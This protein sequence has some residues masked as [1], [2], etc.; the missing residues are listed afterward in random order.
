MNDAKRIWPTGTMPTAKLGRAPRKHQPL[1]IATDAP[2]Q[3]KYVAGFRERMD[4]RAKHAAHVLILSLMILLTGCVTLKPSTAI[5]TDAKTLVPNTSDQSATI[6]RALD[7]GERTLI[8]APGYHRLAK[9]ITLPAGTRIVGTNTTIDLATPS[10]W[11][12]YLTGP[13]SFQGVTLVRSVPGGLTLA[14][15]TAAGAS[16]AFDRVDVGVAT[17]IQNIATVGATGS[18]FRQ[19]T[20]WH[21]AIVRDCTFEADTYISGKTQ[22]TDSIMRGRLISGAGTW[23]LRGATVARVR[24]DHLVSRDNTGEC[25]LFETVDV[26]GCVFEDLEFVGCS[27]PT[28]RRTASRTTSS[29]A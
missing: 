29:A 20:Y 8:F 16:I 10:G 24:W 28:P 21:D 2:Q 18:V 27:G 26:E 19:Q 4:Q 14:T 6:Q 11:A 13:V 22:F 12:F 15:G 7:A 3:A 17:S 25:L 5:D 9:T 23:G 1:F